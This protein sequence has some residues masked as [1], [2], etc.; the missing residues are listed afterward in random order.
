MYAV[1][2]TVYGAG[3]HEE[4]VAKQSTY[5][6]AVRRMRQITRPYEGRYFAQFEDAIGITVPVAKRKI[7]VLFTVEKLA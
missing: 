4:V 2:K 5:R 1:V 3:V 7:V 6:L